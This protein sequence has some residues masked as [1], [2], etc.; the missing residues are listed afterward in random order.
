M[1]GQIRLDKDV[2]D[3]IDK[4]VSDW[5]C[6]KVFRKTVIITGISKVTSEYGRADKDPVY[7]VSFRDVLT[8]AARPND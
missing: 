1:Q 5:L 4:L 8:E 6:E 3:Q 2:T 7:T